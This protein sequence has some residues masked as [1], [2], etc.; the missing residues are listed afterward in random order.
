M[1]FRVKVAERSGTSIKNMFPLNSLWEGAKCGRS[2]CVPCEQEGEEVQNCKKREIIYESI[3]IK[4]N[5]DGRKKGALKDPVT[6]PPSVYIGET[7]RSHHERSREHWD[8]F[9][10]GNKDSHILK[11]HLLH[12]GGE[13]EPEMHF[14]IV[15]SY[16][17][18]LSR[19]VGEAVKIRRR[20]GEGSI[21]NSKGEFIR[22][23]ITRLT[24]GEP[25]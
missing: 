23:R 6:S 25:H 12:H 15:G 22:C 4:C 1:G 9:K 3:C 8:S 18:A 14:K 10:N 7:A 19:Q 13:G 2:N 16:R 24:L 5:P 21:L 11:H 20:G 17:S